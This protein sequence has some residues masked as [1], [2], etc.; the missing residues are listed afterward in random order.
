MTLREGRGRRQMGEVDQHQ[1]G[2]KFP[3]LFPPDVSQTGVKGSMKQESIKQ[4]WT[5]RAS[6]E[7][8]TVEGKEPKRRLLRLRCSEGST[9]FLFPFTLSAR[10]QSQG[11]VAGLG[12]LSRHVIG[13]RR[14]FSL[15]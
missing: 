10:P 12:G 11:N 8:F 6:R 1:T 13:T 14:R 3:I 9:G 5:E 15:C 4:A 7:A 2:G